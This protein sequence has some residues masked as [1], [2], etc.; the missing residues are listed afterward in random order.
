M[1]VNRLLESGKSLVDRLSLSIIQPEEERLDVEISAF[2]LKEAVKSIVTAN[3]GYLITITGLDIPPKVEMDNQAGSPGELEALYHFAN[4]NAIIT[5]R[6]K[7]PYSNPQIES[8]CDLIPSASLYERELMELFGFDF[9]N[10]PNREKL[11]L[12]DTWPDEV[13]PL[14]KSFTG[15]ADQEKNKEE[16]K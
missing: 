13:Y 11:V 5:L 15:L 16:K 12:P 14:R 8:I 3:W 2:N 6:V 4:E 7:I 10:T 1:E 9:V